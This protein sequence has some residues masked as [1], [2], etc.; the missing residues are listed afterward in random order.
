MSLSLIGENHPYIT[1]AELAEWLNKASGGRST[2]T[3]RRIQRL[4]IGVGALQALPAFRTNETVA[5]TQARAKPESKKGTRPVYVTTRSLLRKHLREV[6]DELMRHV[7]EEEA[8]READLL[9]K[10]G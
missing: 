6:Y 8:T 9:D 5:T 7:D 3:P 2:W 10:T 4:L 1:T